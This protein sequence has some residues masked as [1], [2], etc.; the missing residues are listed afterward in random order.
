M[1]VLKR[2]KSFIDGGPGSG[3]QGGGGSSEKEGEL[4]S[5]QTVKAMNEGVASAGQAFESGEESTDID[6]NMASSILQENGVDMSGLNEMQMESFVSN[7]QKGY[8]KRM[9]TLVRSKK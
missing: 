3:P 9:K 5:G 1:N 8:S 4:S 7:F 6:F 2:I